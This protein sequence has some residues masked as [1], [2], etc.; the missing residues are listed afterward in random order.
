MTYR[1]GN[2][3]ARNIYRLTTGGEEHIGCAF[4]ED[5]GRLIVEA[6]N[7]FD[8]TVTLLPPEALTDEQFA[9]FKAAFRSGR[10]VRR[11]LPKPIP[12]PTCTGPVRET[13]G[14]VCQTCGTDYGAASTCEGCNR[15][16]RGMAGGC[17]RHDAVFG[18]EQ[19]ADSCTC[20]KAGPDPDCVVHQG[21][22]ARG[23]KPPPV[24]KGCICDGSG[25]TCPRHGAVL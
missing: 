15:V 24:G 25:R 21:R 13:V 20:T 11:W 10:G 1:N 7:S 6:L 8:V 18:T 12:C 3:N 9:E 22:R 4:T 19:P 17:P 16:R 23:P 5:D 2:R 14:M